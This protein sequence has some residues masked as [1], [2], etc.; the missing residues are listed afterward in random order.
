MGAK[1][2]LHFPQTLLGLHLLFAGVVGFLGVLY[3]GI[4][5]FISYNA[6][7][8][9]EVNSVISE[10][11]IRVNALLDNT[12]ELEAVLLRYAKDAPLASQ[13]KT[14][15]F[16]PFKLEIERLTKEHR[17]LLDRIVCQDE[18]RIKEQFWEHSRGLTD[19]IERFMGGVNSPG[20]TELIQKETAIHFHFLKAALRK[21]MQMQR[22][23]RQRNL[24]HLR[25]LLCRNCRLVGALFVAFLLALWLTWLFRRKLVNKV[26]TLKRY[27]SSIS[28]M[29]SIQKIKYEEYDELNPL[30][31]LFNRVVERIQDK[32]SEIKRHL[33]FMESIFESS[34]DALITVNREGK[35]TYYNTTAAEFTGLSIE[36]A[37][38]RSLFSLHPHFTNCKRHFERLAIEQCPITYEQSIS[39]PRMTRYYQTTLLPLK[40]ETFEGA[41]VRTLDTTEE[42]L[43]DNHLLQSQKMEL[44]RDLIGGIAHDFN[45][46]LGGI[47]STVSIVKYDKSQGRSITE[48]KYEEYFNVIEY[49]TARASDLVSH[50][51]SLAHKRESHKSGIDLVDSVEHILK[52]CRNSFDKTIEISSDLPIEQACSYCDITQLHQVLLNICINASHAMT[53]M[54]AEGAPQGGPSTSPSTPLIPQKSSTPHTPQQ[55]KKTTTRSL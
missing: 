54:R 50:L 49:S 47:A 45:N 13:G 34:P 44:V 53:I 1:R 11:E 2:R 33:D 6:R 20:E 17:A 41:V 19:Q 32:N 3:L 27:L 12:L 10:A 8:W 25:K 39:E 24:R 22:Q 51:V 36:Q 48:E 38:G 37:R 26:E 14:S 31:Q 9:I 29:E 55:P 46:I 15:E 5:F 52:I 43:K 4:Q 35:I 18:K 40:G 30:V 42:K 21:E 16:H 23:R 7:S 28:S